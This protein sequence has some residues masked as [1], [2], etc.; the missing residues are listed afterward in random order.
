MRWR[1]TIG[2]RSPD[3]ECR[4]ECCQKS[5]K[6]RDTLTSCFRVMRNIRSLRAA[7]TDG[8]METSNLPGARRG[9]YQGQLC[10]SLWGSPG[11]RWLGMQGWRGSCRA[12]TRTESDLGGDRKSINHKGPKV[13]EEK[14]AQT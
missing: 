7:T 2:E 4:R 13:D 8:G 9:L 12:E 14:A 10:R 11:T 3:L 5:T 1:S 6:P